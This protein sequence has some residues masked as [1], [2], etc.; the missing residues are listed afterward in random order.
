MN[1][2]ER[3]RVGSQMF[4]KVEDRVDFGYSKSYNTPFSCD[5]LIPNI[6]LPLIPEGE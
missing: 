5:I 6:N 4:W 1:I 2:R 3:V